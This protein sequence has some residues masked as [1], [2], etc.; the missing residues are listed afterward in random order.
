MSDEF[1]PITVPGSVRSLQLD[2]V[3]R[4]FLHAYETPTFPLTSTDASV[5]T[6]V[7]T[8]DTTVTAETSGNPHFQNRKQTHATRRVGNYA[9]ILIE[10]TR[11]DINSLHNLFVDSSV[12]SIV[13][14]RVGLPSQSV[15][16][17]IPVIGK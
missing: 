3:T 17:D 8:I 12:L 5:L 15:T 13:R 7:S 2:V 6:V 4:P 10:I 14:R 9:L 1:N 16:E 11:R